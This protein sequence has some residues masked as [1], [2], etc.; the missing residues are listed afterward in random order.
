[1]IYT[2]NQLDPDALWKA[3]YT[4]C[5]HMNCLGMNKQII[6]SFL[7]KAD[8]IFFNEDGRIFLHPVKN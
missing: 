4:Y 5:K 1:M 7:K 8:N 2:Y 6:D 3:I